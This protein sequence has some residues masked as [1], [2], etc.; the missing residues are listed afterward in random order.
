MSSTNQDTDTPYTRV[1]AQLQD[2]LDELHADD[3]QY[4]PHNPN[5]LFKLEN[6][7]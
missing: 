1:S 3:T 6:A 7:V 4:D 5:E 2:A